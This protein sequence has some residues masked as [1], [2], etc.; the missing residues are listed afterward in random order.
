MVLKPTTINGLKKE[1]LI[2]LSKLATIDKDIVVGRLGS[3][4]V[5]EMVELN[6]NLKVILKLS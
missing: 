5:M 3:L 2:R 6:N 1:S 4:T